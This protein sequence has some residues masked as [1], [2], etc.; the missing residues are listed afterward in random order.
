MPNSPDSNT[1]PS[2]HNN[3]STPP[4]PASFPVPILLST[5]EYLQP[6]DAAIQSIPQEVLFRDQEQRGYHYVRN[7]SA[8][9]AHLFRSRPWELHLAQVC[10]S[11]RQVA[12]LLRDSNC[13]DVSNY[14]QTRGGTPEQLDS[15]FRVFMG[16]PGRCAAA[17]HL[18]IHHR[19]PD[20]DPTLIAD[21]L[22][23]L[24]V[25]EMRTFSLW[26]PDKDYTTIIRAFETAPLPLHLKTLDLLGTHFEDPDA[27]ASLIRFL[28]LIAE[29]APLS[30][31]TLHPALRPSSIATSPDRP[32]VDFA[33]T[34]ASLRSVHLNEKVKSVVWTDLVNAAPNLVH[35]STVSHKWDL[36]TLW[37][38]TLSSLHFDRYPASWMPLL[39]LPASALHQIRDLRLSCY[40]DNLPSLFALLDRTL[41]LEDLQIT[42]ELEMEEFG[43]LVQHA[44][45]GASSDVRNRRR[46]SSIKRLAIGNI[47]NWDVDQAINILQQHTPGLQVFVGWIILAEEHPL[48]SLQRHVQRIKQEVGVGKVSLTD[49]L[50]EE[51]EVGDVDA[52]VG[53]RPTCK[54][55]LSR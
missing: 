54:D 26:N 46:R 10:S 34:F 38:P 23:K 19:H 45:A 8:G 20:E 27:L 35:A 22:Q 1:A 5:F 36:S 49:I 11:W 3:T 9:A 51:G 42:C 47:N 40:P 50:E 25:S 37:Q 44:A 33:A 29:N 43:A 32:F 52:Q 17:R 7:L 13:L 31:L 39:D 53:W 24:N 21:L 12:F 16:D 41:H 30:H 18:S 28:N 15:G 2:P 55:C 48:P 6:K 14:S 4:Y